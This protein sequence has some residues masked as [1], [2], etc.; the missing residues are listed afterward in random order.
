M[1]L[2]QKWSRRRVGARRKLPEQRVDHPPP[3]RD[4]ARWLRDLGLEFRVQRLDRRNY[5]ALRIRESEVLV[6]ATTED[7]NELLRCWGCLR[8][9]FLVAG[10]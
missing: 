1:P 10:R 3:L 4:L 9:A 6:F 2:F 7:S 5:C 8:S